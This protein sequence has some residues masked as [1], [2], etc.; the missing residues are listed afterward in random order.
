MKAIALT[1]WTL[2]CVVTALLFIVAIFVHSSIITFLLAF[3]SGITAYNWWFDEIR[4]INQ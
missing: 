2:L 1:L 3:A 4:Y